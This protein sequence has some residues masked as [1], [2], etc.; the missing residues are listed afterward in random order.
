MIK[1]CG[2]CGADLRETNGVCASC[3][4][5][6]KYSF[7]GVINH[8]NI[9]EGAKEIL[10]KHFPKIL[11]VSLFVYFIMALS[12]LLVEMLLDSK[13]LLYDFA[14]LIRVFVFMP[15]FVGFLGYILKI[16]RNDDAKFDDI[17]RFYDKRI[18]LVFGV[19]F[20]VSLFSVLW[21]FLFVVPGIIAYLS[22]SMC[23][24]VLID[25]CD[26]AVNDIL[27]ES[28][29]LTNGY[30]GDIL[31]FM[32]S[33]IGWYFL[34]ILTLGIALIYVVPYSTVSL[35]MYYDELKKIKNL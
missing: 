7:G 27:S 21:A 2:E 10:D 18:F 5:K 17:F 34:C 33:F 19:G 24:Y 13:T 23:N 30:K 9:K 1:Y 14:S 25:N 15:L 29:R 28:K 4:S 31:L 6:H 32:L 22:Y 35:T 12:M 26:L 8:A 20:L 3:A 16:V 11:R